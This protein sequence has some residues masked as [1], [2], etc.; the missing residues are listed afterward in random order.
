MGTAGEQR[1]IRPR[2]GPAIRRRS[3]LR[4]AGVSLLAGCAPVTGGGERRVTL[5]VGSRQL[6]VS[7]EMGAGFHAGVGQVPEVTAAV[8][9]PETSDGPRAVRM[10]EELTRTSPAGISIFTLNPDMFL[11]PVARAVAAG[12]PLIAVDNPPADTTELGLFVGNDNYELGRLLARAV[13][14]ELAPAPSTGTIVLGTPVPGI[15]VLDLRADGIRDE[16]ARLL[17]RL[18]V[19]GPFDSKLEAAA[20]RAAWTVLVDANLDAVAFVGTGDADS[21]NLGTLRRERGARWTAGA[22]D[23]DPRAL[24]AV[25]T[26]NLVVV[27][28]EHYLKGAIAGRL[29]AAHAAEGAALPK[30]W[31][32]VPG[33]VV[34]TANIERGP[35]PAGVRRHQG[36]QPAEPARRDPR[37]PPRAHLADRDAPDQVKQDQGGQTTVRIST[38]SAVTRMVCSNC[39]VRRRSLVTTVQ[40]SSQMS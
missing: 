27:S 25:R 26:G 19:L 28:P 12:I 3:V 32:R 40:P 18:T 13:V 21:Y 15:T 6:S 10:F 2:I 35:R 23:L 8:T 31:I 5:L 9:G 34:T 17:P 22:F 36:G 29:H 7:K 16:F 1:G 24:E 39:A 33:L 38:P 30:G 14:A 4:A 20:N 37:G 11:E